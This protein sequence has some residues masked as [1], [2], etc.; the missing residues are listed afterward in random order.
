[1][2][3]RRRRSRLRGEEFAR[4]LPLPAAV[5][6]FKEVC[7]QRHASIHST[8]SSNPSR[9]PLHRRTF[10]SHSLSES[11]ADGESEKERERAKHK[12][13]HGTMQMHLICLFFSSLS[14]SLWE[15]TQVE[16]TQNSVSTQLELALSLSLSFLCA[17][18]SCTLF[19]CV[20]CPSP[21]SPLPHPLSLCLS[22]SLSCTLRPSSSSSSTSPVTVTIA[23]TPQFLPQ[24]QSAS[25][26]QSPLLLSIIS[27]F[28]VTVALRWRRWRILTH[29]RERVCVWVSQ[30]LCVC[31]RVCV[32]RRRSVSHAL[33]WGA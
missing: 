21:L 1:M 28:W 8:P 18:Y 32:F 13:R 11:R 26:S 33:L 17:F 23:H 31:V 5:A 16:S 14:I 30:Y 10:D 12:E 3:S 4:K 24:S 20:R 22:V 7:K 25:A 15:A 2:K 27:T 19:A 29:A 9:V 6:S